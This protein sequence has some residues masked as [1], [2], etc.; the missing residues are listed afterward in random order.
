MI[1]FKR[2]SIFLK[3]LIIK[4][5]LYKTEKSKYRLAKYHKF[6]AVKH[7]PTPNVAINLIFIKLLYLSYVL[8]TGLKDLEYLRFVRRYWSFFFLYLHYVKIRRMPSTVLFFNKYNIPNVILEANKLN[9]PIISLADSNSLIHKITYP[10]PSNDDSLILN[11]FYSILLIKTMLLT[12]L[13]K[14]KRFTINK[15]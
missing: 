6:H 5:K 2:H 12:E 7:I 10:I 14:I 3:N 9:L 11:A 4:N 1:G 8:P 13:I 15:F